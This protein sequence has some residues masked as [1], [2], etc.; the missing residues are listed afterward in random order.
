MAGKFEL[1]T[2]NNN[3]FYWRLKAGNGEIILSSQAYKSKDAAINGIE[4]VQANASDDARYERKDAKDDR[5]FFSLKAANGQI[6]GNS[7]MY[8]SAASCENGI[9]SVSENAPGASIYDQTG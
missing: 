9:R 2:G 6:V 7:Q 8:A 5:A 3:Q 1:F 4:S